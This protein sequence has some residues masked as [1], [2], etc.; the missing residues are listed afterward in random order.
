MNDTNTNN[1]SMSDMNSRLSRIEGALPH[2]ATKADI[3]GL[4]AKIY[5][6]AFGIVVSALVQVGLLL[7]FNR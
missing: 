1:T 6:L 7:L 5:L 4:E 2:L 3:K